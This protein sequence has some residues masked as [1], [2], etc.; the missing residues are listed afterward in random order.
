[1]RFDSHGQLDT[2]FGSGGEAIL[3][4]AANAIALQLNGQILVVSAALPGVTL[5]NANATVAKTF[6]ISSQAASVASP[7]TVAVQGDGRI[8]AAGTITTGLASPTIFTGNPTGFG[9]VRFNTDGSIDTTF[10]LHGGT[11]TGFPQENLGRVFSMAL[12]LDGDIVAGG[13][14]GKSGGN[15][16]ASSFALARYLSTGQLDNT[17]GTGGRV[18]TSFGSTNVAFIS[19]IV[20]QTDGKI[21]AAGTSGDAVGD[22]AVARYLGQ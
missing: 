18:T 7:S 21:V 6:G 8:L 5:Y 12:Q 16:T 4:T 1:M 2:T 10:G 13:Q 20:L 9:L 14:A 15:G 11:I 3:L 17:F 22:F 19:G